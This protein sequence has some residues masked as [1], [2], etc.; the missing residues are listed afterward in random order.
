MYDMRLDEYAKLCAR[1]LSSFKADFYETYKK[2]PGK[3]LTGKGLEYTKFLIETTDKSINDVAFES[4]FK[5][6]SHFVR[7]FRPTYGNPP[8]QHWLVH[9]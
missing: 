2:T 6:T 8:L 9:N 1:S 4:G 7:I 5:N 3:W